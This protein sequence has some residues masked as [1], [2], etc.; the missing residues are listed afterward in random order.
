MI[1]SASSGVR[2][3]L[4]PVNVI[5]APIILLGLY[6]PRLNRWGA[7][8]SLIYGPVVVII[9]HLHPVLDGMIYALIPAFAVSFFGAILMSLLTGG[10]EGASPP[11]GQPVS[12]SG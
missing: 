5:S 9:W 2:R 11:P 10:T 7:L 8:A 3:L 1:P 4:T 6:W 12:R